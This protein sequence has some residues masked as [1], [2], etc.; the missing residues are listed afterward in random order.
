MRREE[1][2]EEEERWVVEIGRQS[3]EG[4][5]PFTRC[6]LTVMQGSAL[7]RHCNPLTSLVRHMHPQTDRQS[8]NLPLRSPSP[9]IN[10][11]THRLFLRHPKPPCLL[12]A[13]MRR[14]RPAQKLMLAGDGVV[15]VDCLNEGVCDRW[16][17]V[18]RE[19]RVE[20]HTARL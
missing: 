16:G 19:S 8:S 9:A 11:E 13:V 17:V 3:L 2:G 6:Q 18:E 15:C 20:Y 12:P 1:S 4:P 14:T 7:L 5:R 10:T